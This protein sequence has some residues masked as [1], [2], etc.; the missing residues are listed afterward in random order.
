M[1]ITQWASEMVHGL[2]T[3]GTGMGITL[4]HLFTKPVTM[5]YPDEKWTMPEAFRGLL[6]V[7]A[8]VCMGCE[9]CAKACPV[10]CITIETK[11]E[12]GRQGKVATRFEIDYQKCMYCGLCVEPCPGGAIWHSNEYENAGTS[13]ADLVIDWALPENRVASPRAKPKAKPAP[14]PAAPEAAPAAKP[15][16]PP[17]PAKA[18]AP[19]SAPGAEPPPPAPPAGGP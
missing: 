8:N 10:D 11:R 16:A 9:L 19:P 4:R 1:S 5:H 15:D 12:P 17:T 14:K 18:E 3:V 6:K 2:R 7:D 13:R